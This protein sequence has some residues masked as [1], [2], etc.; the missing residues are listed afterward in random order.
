M[1]IKPE[2][3]MKERG[4]DEGWKEEEWEIAEVTECPKCGSKLE[5]KGLQKRRRVDY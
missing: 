5:I 1:E 2:E 3:I 4:W